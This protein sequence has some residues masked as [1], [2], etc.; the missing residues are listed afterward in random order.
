MPYFLKSMTFFK[1]INNDYYTKYL[2]NGNAI[3]QKFNK[4]ASGQSL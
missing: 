1:H 2:H 4:I 3:M